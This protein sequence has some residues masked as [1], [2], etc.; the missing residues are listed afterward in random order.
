MAVERISEYI[1]LESEADWRIRNPAIP[2]G[3]NGWPSEGR[4]KFFKFS[5]RYRLELEPV[6]H[7]LS[8]QINTRER[9]GVVGRTG[10]GI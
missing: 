2:R 8:F 1:G 6:L 5:L 9:V 10:A 7:D 3:L 4:I